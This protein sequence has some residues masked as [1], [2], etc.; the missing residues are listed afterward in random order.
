MSSNTREYHSDKREAQKQQTR[1][2]ILEGLVT[3]MSTGLA[4]IT[5]PAVAQAAGVSVP[6]VYRYFPN[7]E[8]L[9][10]AL[11]SH[12]GAALGIAPLSM[13]TTVA[14]LA[15]MV[16][17]IYGQLEGKDALVRAALVSDLTTRVRA[18]TVP[19]RLG[20][21][22]HVLAGQVQGCSEAE[23]TRLRNTLFI[24]SSSAVVNAFKDYLGLSWAEAADHV[25]WA[26]QLLAA[27]AN[28]PQGES[29]DT[30]DK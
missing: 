5:I 1:A 25:S 10:E 29:H 14:D 2:Q 18:V 13:P 9:L 6:T 12:L 30:H 11:P 24:L 23:R 22:E 4:D 8:A 20:L 3:V 19:R 21:I 7:K 27:A 15:E 16:R 26:M 28:N 17:Q